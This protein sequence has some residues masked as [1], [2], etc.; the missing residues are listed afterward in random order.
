MSA[1]LLLR[2]ANASRRS[3][4]WSE[5][6]FDSERN[7]GRVFQQADGSWF[8]GVSF[9]LT[10]KEPQPAGMGTGGG[11]WGSC[12]RRG[13]RNQMPKQFGGSIEHGHDLVDVNTFFG[14]PQV[15]IG[16]GDDSGGKGGRDSA[17][18]QLAAESHDGTRDGTQPRRDQ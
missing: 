16:D 2:R 5:T 18:D 10:A 17:P 4:S 12:D 3:G 13:A 11:R 8:W 6:D 1:S 14:H 9:Q 7:V 15:I